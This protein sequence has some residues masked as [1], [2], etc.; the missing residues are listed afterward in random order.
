MFGGDLK[1]LKGHLEINRPLQDDT[2][3]EHGVSN[4]NEHVQTCPICQKIVHKE[5]M[6]THPDFCEAPHCV[7][8]WILRGHL[9]PTPNATI[10]V[11]FEV[12]SIKFW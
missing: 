11:M 3:L 4:E 7:F 2:G 10:S 9:M 1:T 6:N 8:K 12:I 5:F